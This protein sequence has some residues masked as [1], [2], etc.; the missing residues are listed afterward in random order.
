MQGESEG[1]KELEYNLIFF[2]G[3]HHASRGLLIS[4]YCTEIRFLKFKYLISM[5]FDTLQIFNCFA[6]FFVY[7]IVNLNL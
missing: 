1:N 3:N 2:A 4:K 6:K 5:L 7:F